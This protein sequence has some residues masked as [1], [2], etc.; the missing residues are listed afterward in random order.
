MA[1]PTFQQGTILVDEGAVLPGGVTLE[2]G[3]F[4]RN[5]RS[6][7]NL[8]RTALAAA[9]S[10]AGWTFFFMAGIVQKHAFGRDAQKRL[11][12]AVARVIEDVHAQKCN[13]VEITHLVTKSFLG[14]PYLS[15]T[16]HARHIQG[17]SQF[18]GAL[19]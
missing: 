1:V 5:W 13:C 8:D 9:I 19:L 15:I 11:Q 12:T 7:A 16:A 3:T 2:S 18:S 14:L 4:P 17:S 10:K 6:V